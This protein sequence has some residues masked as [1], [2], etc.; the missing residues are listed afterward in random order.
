MIRRFYPSVTCAIGLRF[1][2]ALTVLKAVTPSKQVARAPSTMSFI[3]QQQARLN[4][5]P[6]VEPL[7]VSSGNSDP[8]SWLVNI[9]PRAASY[10]KPGFRD[11]GT[12]R[13]DLGYHDLPI[14]PRLIKAAQV[15]IFAGCVSPENFARGV[16]E[17]A[18]IGTGNQ[19]RSSVIQGIAKDGSSDPNLL[20]IWGAVDDFGPVKFGDNPTLTISGRDLRSIFISSPMRRGQ[21]ANLDLTKDIV[22]VVNELISRHPLGGQ[23]GIKAR[24]DEWPNGQIPSPGAVGNLT[25]VHLDKNKKGTSGPPP[26]QMESKLTWWDAICNYSY[27][28]GAVPYFIGKDLVVRP[29][30]SLYDL[31]NLDPFDPVAQKPFLRSR[32]GTNGLPSGVRQLIYG[33]NVSELSYSRKL[34]GPDRPKIIQVTSLDTS[35]KVRG[36]G[37][38]LRA[39]YP[40]DLA[41]QLAK[42]HATKESPSGQLAENEVLRVPI[43]GVNGQDQLDEIARA[44]FETTA[45]FEIE[46]SFETRD[47]ASY[48]QED[49][50]D[51][52]DMLRLAPGDPIEISVASEKL[53]NRSVGDS[54]IVS[55]LTNLNGLD[56]DD[57]VDQT[58]QSVGDVN[59]ARA[60]VAT[61]RGLVVELESTY[62]ISEVTVDWNKDTG[63]KVSGKFHNFIEA[64]YGEKSQPRPT[65]KT[66]AQQAGVLP[67]KSVLDGKSLLDNDFDS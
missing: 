53:G 1:D 55:D 23:M 14:D 44:I 52:P 25:A 59:L 11:A 5:I 2:D 46:G 21:L 63:A 66:T 13:I 4:N 48:T 24:A 33:H 29:A 51:D 12:F 9:V 37:K 7:F 65:G 10:T 26:A 45:R 15:R 34:Q 40:K 30:R 38:L 41:K 27:L 42:L 19:V 32:I 67:R 18:T 6:S 28:V 62:R 36:Q 60:I 54:P 39:L 57:A 61:S 35:G 16:T 43:W 49:G 22:S 20:A 8:L 31:R 56:Y 50:N 17:V 64:R 3:A 58:A 47:L